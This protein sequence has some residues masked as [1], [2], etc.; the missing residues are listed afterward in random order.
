MSLAVSWAQISQQVDALIEENALLRRQIAA[1]STSSASNKPKL[2][3][4]EVSL[5]KQLKR[6]G[7]T[8]AELAAAFGVNPSTVSRTIRGIYNRGTA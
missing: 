6:V 8:N 5:M 3:R 2:T 1:G 7:S 4:R